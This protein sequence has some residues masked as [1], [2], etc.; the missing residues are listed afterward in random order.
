METK[1]LKIGS[2]CTGY[3]GL[4]MAIEA[5]TGGVTTWSSEID[6]ASIKLIN[7]RFKVP[8][9]GNLTKLDWS[10]IE[11]IDILTAGYPCQPFSHAGS[12]K[13]TNDPR[14]IWPSIKEAIR[15]LR[16]KGVFM[17]NVTGHLNL[18]FS[19][20]L[21]DLAEIG[22]NAQWICLRASDVG[23]PHRRERLFIFAYPN[24]EFAKRQLLSELG[25]EQSS[26]R[27]NLFMQSKQG[28]V[29]TYSHPRTYS[30][31][32]RGYRELRAE[33]NRLR[34]GQDEG[35]AGQV[36]RGSTAYDLAI[37]HWEGLTRKAPDS[38]TD[39]FV[40]TRFIEWLMG[41]PE[42]WVT[43]MGFTRIQES[44]LLGN[45]VVPAQAYAAYSLILDNLCKS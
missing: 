45:G 42:G 22:F 24:D 25:Y 30:Q 20:V 31:L 33:G 16:P 8:Q 23:A 34:A 39:G 6:K 7:E 32:R 11:P 38:L 12:R 5:L 28:Q 37:E 36:A 41:L 1:Q 44:K 2:L 4:D 29:T 15:I 26:S 27:F 21:G 10:K 9:I 35:Q 17:E 19:N 14:H 43:G 13:G 3:G 40:D 18:G